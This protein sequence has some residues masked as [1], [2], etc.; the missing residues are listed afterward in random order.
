MIIM[1]EQEQ[2]E[3]IEGNP[4][5]IQYLEEPTEKVQWAAAEKDITAVRYIK[6]PSLE[7][8]LYAAKRDGYVIKYLTNPSYEVQKEAV[9]RDGKAI[10]YVENQTKELQK[11]AIEENP[12]A[13]DCIY[14]PSEELQLFTIE[15]DYRAIWLIQNPSIEVAF[16]AF[17]KMNKK[18]NDDFLVYNIHE[19]LFKNLEEEEKEKFLTL[20][21]NYQNE[22]NKPEYFEGM[23]HYIIHNQK[24]WL[25]DYL[26]TLSPL[27]KEQTDIWNTLRLKAL[28]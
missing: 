3:V 26:K 6:N 21:P 11:L 5:A 16:Q 25:H 20:L 23:L 14:N 2:F 18:A 7:L 24:D 9:K 17:V 1:T 27:S 15:K 19:P 4:C 28:L 12:H 8:Q 22:L 10:E 13:I